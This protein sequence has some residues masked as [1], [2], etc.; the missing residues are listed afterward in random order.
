MQV[1]EMLA[2]TGD[3]AAAAAFRQALTAE[4]AIRN[5]PFQRAAL[6]RAALPVLERAN[7]E[8][9][10][11]LI[12]TVAAATLV[13]QQTRRGRDPARNVAMADTEGALRGALAAPDN[14]DRQRQSGAVLQLVH[15]DLSAKST[16][17]S[18]P[19]PYRQGAQVRLIEVIAPSLTEQDAALATADLLDLLSRTEDYLT[20]ATVARALGALAPKLRGP[21]RAQALA[22]AKVAL[23]KTGSSEEATAFARAIAAL[24][25]AERAAATAEIIEALKYPTATEAPSDVLVAALADVWPEEHKAIAGRTLPD[26][27]VLDWLEL[28]LPAGERLTDP[29]Q[30]PAGLKLTGA[31]LSSR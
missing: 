31:G 29:P 27:T 1:V 10:T 6:A 16:P 22:A 13:P 26:Q 25:P 18:Q 28:R 12:A 23:A 11:V 7:G 19:D 30:R 20:R 15:K 4:L 21:E 9:A 24:L 5:E 14:A 8:S 3:Q 2:S 17:N